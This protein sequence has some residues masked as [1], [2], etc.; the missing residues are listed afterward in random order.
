MINKTINLFDINIGR[1]QVWLNNEIAPHK[2]LASQRRINQS[3]INYTPRRRDLFY[4]IYPYIQA[5]AEVRNNQLR[6]LLNKSERRQS[7]IAYLLQTVTDIRNSISSDNN[8]SSNSN[9]NTNN[10]SNDQLTI[11]NNNNTRNIN[12]RYIIILLLSGAL[13]VFVLL[14]FFF[15]S[16]FCLAVL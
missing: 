12:N 5:Q 13:C 16:Y 2:D 9:N 6:M 7:R 8:G 1:I 15:L 4:M 11:S 10:T 3:L 14:I